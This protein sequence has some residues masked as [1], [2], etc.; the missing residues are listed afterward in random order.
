VP[1]KEAIAPLA[2]REAERVNDPDRWTLEASVR[3]RVLRDSLGVGIA[4][5]AYGLSF[6][7][8]SS[9]AGLSIPETCVL[10]LLAFTGASQFAFI[11]SAANPVAATT[12][13]LLLG[14]RNG[15]YSLRTRSIVRPRGLTRLLAAQ[16]T[17]DETTAMASAQ[18][19]DGAARLAFWATGASVYTL[20]N[21]ATL[22]GAI[23]A[24]KLGSPQRFG[25]DAAE[26][27]AF[28]ALL[29]PRL[30]D[31]STVIVAAVGALVALASTPVS[32]AGVP[33]LLAAL[34]AVIAGVS[35]PSR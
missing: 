33:I 16:W 30:R 35:E 19:S 32:P 31:R 28:L 12:S 6:G 27:A 14:V 25:L 4:T 3:R 8:L 20:W 13:A 2:G 5:G 17:I 21:L 26:P 15:F 29:A 11:G 1:E 18:E 7:A 24:A 34:V 23:G 9:A 22:L 10:S